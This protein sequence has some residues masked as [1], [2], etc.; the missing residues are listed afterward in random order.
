MLDLRSRLR[1]LNGPHV[2]LVV[3]TNGGAVIDD[4]DEHVIA[5]FNQDPETLAEAAA[6]AGMMTCSVEFSA[7]AIGSAADD[8]TA[9]PPDQALPAC[10]NDDLGDMLTRLSGLKTDATVVVIAANAGITARSTN[11]GINYFYA[12]DIVRLLHAARR[13]YVPACIVAAESLAPPTPE[14]QSAGLSIAEALARCGR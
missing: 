13:L 8:P 5:G 9:V 12:D 7:L 14:G 4:R 6:A 3:G 1:Q 10:L 2:W 11:G